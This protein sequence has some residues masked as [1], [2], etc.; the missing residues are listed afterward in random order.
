MNRAI[1]GTSL[2]GGRENGGNEPA[3][4]RRDEKL[5]ETSIANSACTSGISVAS[6][7]KRFASWRTRNQASL[8]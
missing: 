7:E 3:A 2:G 5:E 4:E 6:V 1:L 8:E